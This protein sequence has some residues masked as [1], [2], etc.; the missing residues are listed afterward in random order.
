MGPQSLNHRLC[1]KK[2]VLYFRGAAYIFGNVNH[3]SGK[4]E[5]S[6]RI[7]S[8]HLHPSSLYSLPL[9]ACNLTIR[10]L[11]H[12]LFKWGLL[13]RLDHWVARQLPRHWNI[14]SQSL[15][16]GTG[17][18]HERS[19][20]TLLPGRWACADDYSLGEISNPRLL[21]RIIQEVMGMG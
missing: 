19:L 15:R 5:A 11:L 7:T 9:Q 21:R 13:H 4:R 18:K 10:Q 3:E 14:Q 12:C 2:L 6:W 1:T 17:T 20:I 8:L 16:L